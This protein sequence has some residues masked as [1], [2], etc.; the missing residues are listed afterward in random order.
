MMTVD[1]VLQELDQETPATR[2][3][4]ERVPEHQLS[5]RPHEKS[6]TLGQ[7]A[8]HVATLPGVIA[9]LSTQPGLDARTNIPRPQPASTAE[10]MSAFD[11]SLAQAKSVLDHMDNADLALPW[12]MMLGNEEIASMPRGA[13]IRS[14]LLNHWYHHR[15][16]LMVYLRQTGAKVPAVYGGSADENPFGL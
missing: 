4:L 5:W 15:G 16:Q 11:Q 1:D 10:V 14:I 3:V 9:E 7:L 13:L 6:L 8:M 12:R 2:R